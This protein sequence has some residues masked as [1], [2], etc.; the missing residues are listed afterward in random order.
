MTFFTLIFGFTISAAA[1]NS[2][3][4]INNILQQ[5]GYKAIPITIQNNFLYIKA[6]LNNHPAMAIIDTGSSGINVTEGTAKKLKLATFNTTKKEG[7]DM[8][9]KKSFKKSVILPHISIGNIQLSDVTANIFQH[10]SPSSIPTLVVGRNFLQRHHAVIDVYNKKLYLGNKELSQHEMNKI[11]RILLNQH[12]LA[13]PLMFLGS[14]SI[15][16]SLQINH[17]QPVNF[18]FDTGTGITL[19]SEE[20]AK[21]LNLK[22]SNKEKEITIEKLVMNPLNLSFQPII[23]LNSI[24]VQ[25]ENLAVLRQYLYVQGIFGLSDMIKAR[26]IIFLEEGIVFLR[27]D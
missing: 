26:A 25:P 10:V 8:H 18:L 27:S 13:V 16:M 22:K 3:P 11:Q 24:S 20:Y 21:T 15:V 17:S 12:L 19:L 5:R 6:S 1:E 7:V 23:S 2:E 9:G 14:G 4:S